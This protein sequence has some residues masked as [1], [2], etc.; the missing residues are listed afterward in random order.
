[1]ESKRNILNV[2]SYYDLR[3]YLVRTAFP[4]PLDEEKGRLCLGLPPF[5]PQDPLIKQSHVD[6][7]N[8]LCALWMLVELGQ[9]GAPARNWTNGREQ[10]QRI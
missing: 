4:L 3:T 5:A 7:I 10:G 1:M 8:M 6:H 9:R 2:A